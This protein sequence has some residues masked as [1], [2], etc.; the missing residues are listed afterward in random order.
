MKIQ[1][2]ITFALSCLLIL[3][4]PLITQAAELSS[5]PGQTIESG[6][7]EETSVQGD[8]MPV[9]QETPIQDES[10]L[11]ITLNQYSASLSA[12]DTLQLSASTS[13][14][15]NETAANLP[16]ITWSSEHADIAT[17]SPQGLVT[18][19]KMGTAKITA[20]AVL[21]TED[22]TY[23][24]A[25]SCTITVANTI[26]LNKKK[27]SLYTTQTA[28]LTAETAPSGKVT[29]HSSNTAIASVD[30]NGKL[31]AKKAGS[32]KI[33]ASANGVSASCNVTV[34]APSLYLSSSKTIYLKNPY[35]LKAT[36]KPKGSVTWKSSN[37]KIA[38]VS[39]K[40]KIT[41]KKTGTVTITASCH[42]IKKS[43]KVTV[44]N[45]SVKLPVKKY[46]VFAE[47]NC[48]LK[49]SAHPSSDVSYRTSN[50]KV[51]KVSKDGTLK[52]IRS[53]TA[54]ITA[55]V[56]GAEDSCE[57]TV[58]KNNYKLNHSSQILMK[59][60]NMTLYM[61]NVPADGNISYELSDP[62][63][64][65]LSSSGNSCKITAR[66]A[67]KTTLNAYYTVYQDGMYATCKRSCKITV[68]DSGIV[69][70]QT[71]IAAG[72]AKTLTLKHIN[73]PDA[74]VKRIS[75]KSSNP[76]V[77]SI[78]HKSG[79][80]KGRKSGSVKITATV[81]YSDDTSKE[82]ATQLKVSHPQTVY[83]HTVLSL[84]HS[85]K[86]A[87]QGLTSYSDITWKLKKKSPVSINP[88]G[89]VT[90]G[91]TTGTTTVT[92]NA[93]GKTIKH[94]IIVTNPSLPSSYVVL[95]PNGTSRIRLSGVSSQ[96]KIIYRSRKKSVATVSKS[97][98]VTAHKYGNANIS[99]IADGIAFT[100][101]VNVAPQRAV[102]ACNI[103][104]SIMYSSSYSQARRMSN[105]YYD[106]SSLVF[107]SYGCDTGLLGGIPSWAPTAASMASYLERHGKVI[108]Y[109]G[110][111]SSQLRP[112]DLMF[113]GGGY[114]GRYKNIYH[115]S[116][117][118]G[119]GYRLEK[120]LREYYPEGNIVMIAR[121]VR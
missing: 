93:D 111:N 22:H 7:Q 36:V 118:F 5:I 87:L 108:A 21:H 34:K 31:S 69:Q 2:L 92:I 26:S 80:V 46:L 28:Q 61:S 37:Q 71:A 6:I 76:K 78:G 109:R 66:E 68:I 100:F 86:V 116:M 105:G 62:S 91:N 20:T 97:G 98:V 27:L 110:L 112:G 94:T 43:C 11:D 32:A 95:A 35:K 53:G 41:P 57:V 60:S 29:W 115:V 39:A 16:Q 102:D 73:K 9:Q 88:D 54:T 44:K 104:Y 113:F 75:W 72:T 65:K 106:C 24:A 18:A 99:V 42:G 117:Y 45:P 8:N 101:Q 67:G 120:P 77:A 13:G 14:H 38:V 59:G 64:A 114:N 52:G 96:S 4:T 23:T 84:G 3:E 85:Q 25:V 50:P 82:Y 47:N 90:A 81:S 56:P 1:K 83:K 49:I 12:G 79:K 63:I 19:V 55:S 121:P 107:R 70:Q 17:V 30:A 103:G 15:E 10:I 58:L 48:D 51:A 119:G 89:T 40:G 33:T 74:K